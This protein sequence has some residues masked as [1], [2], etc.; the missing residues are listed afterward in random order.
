MAKF[1]PLGM[2]QGFFG[3]KKKKGG[4]KALRK[5]NNSLWYQSTLNRHAAN[6][7]DTFI[8]EQ[9]ERIKMQNAFAIAETVISIGTGVLTYA[10]AMQERKALEQ[11]REYIVGSFY[12]VY[13]SQVSV[14]PILANSG[15]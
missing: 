11:E 2:V 8:G 6:H 3:T 7:W 1:S 5:F 15:K 14:A 10:E 9:Q 12:D 4:G 13:Q